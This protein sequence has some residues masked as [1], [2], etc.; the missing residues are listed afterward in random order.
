[1]RCRWS[2]WFRGPHRHRP[3]PLTEREFERADARLDRA[4]APTCWLCTAIIENPLTG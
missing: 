2:S 4:S 1:M 3:R